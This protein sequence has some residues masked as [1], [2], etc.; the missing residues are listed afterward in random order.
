MTP[1]K[2][3]LYRMTIDQY[4][5]IQDGN[6]GCHRVELIKGVMHCRQTGNHYR[7]Q[8]DEFQALV[9]RGILDPTVLDPTVVRLVDGYLV[10]SAGTGPR[11][12]RGK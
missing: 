6:L 4:E 10:Q 3:S 7:F 1:E 11:P 2:E 12:H 8:P 9:E 5:A